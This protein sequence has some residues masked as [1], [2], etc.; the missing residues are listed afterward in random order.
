M[1]KWDIRFSSFALTYAVDCIFLVDRGD[2]TNQSRTNEP[3]MCFFFFVCAFPSDDF[4]FVL[5][6][7]P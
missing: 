3:V 2:I 4:V 6:D 7:D 5:F 1:D